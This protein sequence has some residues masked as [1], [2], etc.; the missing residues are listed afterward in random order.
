[1]T[2]EN[3]DKIEPLA[4]ETEIK[5]YK[6]YDKTHLLMHIWYHTRE[7]QD[8]EDLVAQAYYILGFKDADLGRE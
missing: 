7:I 3:E 6:A 2:I 8:I 5:L 1:M 4:S